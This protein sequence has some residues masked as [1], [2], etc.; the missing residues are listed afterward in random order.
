MH[1]IGGEGKILVLHADVI[2]TTNRKILNHYRN[3]ISSLDDQLR[4]K[5]VT[6]YEA[7]VMTDEQMRFAAFFGFIPTGEEL[8]FNHQKWIVPIYKMKKEL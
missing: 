1:D 2:P 4:S 7:W 8:S 5:G 3:I 6:E